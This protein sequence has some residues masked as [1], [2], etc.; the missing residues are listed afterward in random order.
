MCECEGEGWR[1]ELK[2]VMVNRYRRIILMSHL[3]VCSGEVN[4]TFASSSHYCVPTTCTHHILCSV[5]VC[6]LD[7]FC[8][9]VTVWSLSGG[10][11]TG[12][13]SSTSVIPE[14]ESGGRR[15]GE[16]GG[17]KGRERRKERERKEEGENNGWNAR[18]KGKGRGREENR[19]GGGDGKHTM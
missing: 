6:K 18:V 19:R 11:S 2:D 17:R 7:S 13:V 12:D 1:E 15:E 3:P 14:R 8:H 4:G 5:C 10:L 16:E 9:L